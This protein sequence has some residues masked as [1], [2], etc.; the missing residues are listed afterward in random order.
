MQISVPFPCARGR[1]RSFL[2]RTSHVAHRSACIKQSAAPPILQQSI[3]PAT[4]QRRPKRTRR[5]DAECACRRA[6]CVRCLPCAQ[7][8]LSPALSA[9][10]SSSDCLAPRMLARARS[11]SLLFKRPLAATCRPPAPGSES[12]TERRKPPS[13]RLLTLL[14]LHPRSSPLSCSTTT[15]PVSSVCSA[16]APL[17]SSSS[18]SGATPSAPPPP[19][20]FIIVTRFQVREALDN[21]PAVAA[22]GGGGQG[23]AAGVVRE[24]HGRQRD[25]G[26]ADVQRHRVRAAAYVRD[27]PL[28]PCKTVTPCTCTAPT[29]SRR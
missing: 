29:P 16:P 27:T 18:G 17:H 20:C 11:L 21:A 12:Q 14:V 1:W 19:A 9:R 7:R 22:G 5:V 10:H 15:A 28:P 13:G 8:R 24:P 6:R 4:Q 25:G 2:R 23:A 26:G 3:A